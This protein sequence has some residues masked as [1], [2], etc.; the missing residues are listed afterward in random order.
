MKPKKTIA[1]AME[2]DV[3]KF[4]RLVPAQKRSRERYELILSTAAEI[5]AEKGSESFKMSDIV[6]RAGVPHGS[7]YQYFADK[8]AVIATL[9]ERSNLEGRACVEAELAHVRNQQELHAALLRIIDG[10]Y[11]MFL[12]E[13]LL[14]DIWH[15]TQSDRKLQQLDADDMNA[16]VDILVKVMQRLTPECDAHKAFIAS[17]M[18]M[19]L[20]AAAVRHAISI[21]PEDGE[22]TLNAFKRVFPRNLSALLS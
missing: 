1:P 7:L 2:G 5:I 16:L 15:A 17:S 20:I 3:L 10:Y 14:K 8:V 11:E 13:P 21:E 19:H 12:N 18:I 6:E 9:A 4:Q 22:M